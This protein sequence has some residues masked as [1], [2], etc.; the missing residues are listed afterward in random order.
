MGQMIIPGDKTRDNVSTS[1]DNPDARLLALNRSGTSRLSGAIPLN[2]HYFWRLLSLNL[3]NA[4]T[5]V[6]S[7]IQ[8]GNFQE[9]TG[10]GGS[11]SSAWFS[12][13]TN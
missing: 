12:P 13:T 10:R 9:G 3:S 8:I 1:Y 5:H 4:K 7:F 2:L 11:A 6:A